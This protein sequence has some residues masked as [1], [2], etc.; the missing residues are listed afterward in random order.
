MTTRRKFIKNI[1][2]IGATVPLINSLNATANKSKGPVIL[3]S[4]GEIWG[5]KVLQPGWDILSGGGTLLDAIEKSANV[6]ELDPDDTSVGYGGLPNEHGIVQLDASIMYGPTHNCGS[7]A[8]LEGIKTPCSVARLVMERTDH[9]HI[10]G[11]GAQEFARVH[12]F[13]I[14]NLLTDRA[15]KIWLRWKENLSDR[16]D[17][18]PPSDGNYDMERTTGTINVLAIDS[19]ND[20]AGITTTSGLAYKIP[21]RVGDSPIIGA[22]LYVDNEVGAAGATG[23]GEEIIR[24]CG[25]F[26][27]V[28]QMRNGKSPQE[29]CEALCKR[30]IDINGGT[31]NINFNDKI[32]ALGKD[33]SV[34][35]A[36]IKEK[37]G[38]EPKLA[39]W[40]NDGFNVYKGTY[41]IED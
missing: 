31:K 33:G 28:E 7:V 34:G 4:R 35:C 9:I 27:V 13:K 21:G 36:S 32:V 25:S 17:W 24:T 2:A 10:V 19:K 23:R 26:F 29:A 11:K 40:S 22:G 8:A 16:D 3:C 37:K 15:R 20:V 6:T 12:G 39:Y 5:E 41:L 38:N 18:F 1:S 14:E 30:I